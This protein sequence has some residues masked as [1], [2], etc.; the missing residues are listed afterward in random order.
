MRREALWG[1]L[2]LGIALLEGCKFVNVMTEKPVIRLRLNAGVSEVQMHSTYQFAREFMQGIPGKEFITAPHVLIYQ[3][4][5]L[6][7]RIEEAGGL[8]TL[9]TL[10]GYSVRHETQDPESTIKY[11]TVHILPDYVPLRVALD[12]AMKLRDELAAQGFRA[13]NRAWETRFN[14]R[15]KAAPP[16]LDAFEDLEPAILNSMFFVKSANVFEMQKGSLN[17]ELS[18][19]NGRRKFGSRTDETDD[20]MAPVEE[21]A[22]KEAQTFSQKDLLAEPSYSLEL[23]IGPTDES[24]R[25]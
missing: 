2:L 6:K 20:R 9:P 15:F 3:D 25:N 23:S 7:L 19:T 4:D 24:R 5:T 21:R 22:A 13:Q 8:R 12:R 17:I 18:I 16:N 14:A 10:I 11:V 1:T